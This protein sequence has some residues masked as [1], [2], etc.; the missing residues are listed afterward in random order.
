[1]FI[2][3]SAE[4]SRAMGKKET[5][6]EFELDVHEEKALQVRPDSKVLLRGEKVKSKVPTE[7]IKHGL[8]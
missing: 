1:M 8:G 4:N 2:K 5:G 6:A 7:H 3:C